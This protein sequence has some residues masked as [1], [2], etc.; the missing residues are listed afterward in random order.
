MELN[1]R[2]RETM[3]ALSSPNRFHGAI[4]SAFEW[5]KKRK[6]WRIDTLNGKTYLLIL[7]ETRPELSHALTQFGNENSETP[8]EVAVYDKLLDRIEVGSVWQ[9]R[10]VANPTKSINDTFKKERGSVHAHIT[11]Q[12]QEQWLMDKASKCGF[13]LKQ[14]EFRKESEKWYSFKKG[15]DNNR[16]TILSVTFEGLLTVTNVEL[17]KKAMTEGIGKGKAYGMGLLTIV[18]A[19]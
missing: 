10:L 8:Y 9:F 11:T 7:S 2:K 19:R 5:D 12:Y 13:S 14:E 6:L 15:T 18:T 17:F 3:I 4:E 16:V 1:I